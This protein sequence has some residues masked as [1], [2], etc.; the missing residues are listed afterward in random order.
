[1]VKVL[2]DQFGIEH[3]FMTTVHAYTADQNLQDSPHKDLRRA[4]AAAHSIIPTS[5]GAAKA[6]G[7]VMP[8]LKGKL[9]GTME[10]TTPNGRRRSRQVTPRLTSSIRP[11]IN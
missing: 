6:V 3:G 9:N 10:T 2:D 11:A 4:R 1:M 8:H 7:I 5:T